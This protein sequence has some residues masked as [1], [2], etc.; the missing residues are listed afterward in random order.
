ME[1]LSSKGLGAKDN[2]D[3]VAPP[4]M[5]EAIGLLAEANDGEDMEMDVEA[6]EDDGNGV[7]AA[8]GVLEQG[9]GGA[10]PDVDD[11]LP[12]AGSGWEDES[13]KA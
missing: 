11:D 12:T 3:S 8:N 2:E 7:V 9:A 13:D 1:A 4:D 10:D 5:K 6:P